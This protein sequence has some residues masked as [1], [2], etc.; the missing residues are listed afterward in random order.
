MVMLMG[1][2]DLSIGSIILVSAV[3]T[4][5]LT[6]NHGLA[7]W[8]AIGAG[9]LAA[10]GIGL[11]NGIFIA[12]IGIEPII[13]TLGTLIAAQGLG[14][15]ILANEG[16]WIQVTNPFF[17]SVATDQV[18]TLPLMA[19]IMLGFYAAAAVLLRD[20]ALGRHIYAIGGNRRAARLAGIPMGR[21]VL[22]TYA[23]CGL[24]AGMAGMLEIAQLGI[25]SQ[26][27]GEGMQFNAITAVLVGGISLSGGSGR[28]EKTLLGILIVGT[29]T[30]YLT[31]RGVSAYYEQAITGGI[32]LAAVFLDHATR[33]RAQ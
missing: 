23:L 13:V 32:I 30:N 25:V 22:A 11:V 5:A 1:G 28:V 31:F 7:A 29:I 12:G 26:N 19:V 14:Q 20:T 15:A 16:S 33:R 9:L 24:C 21:V 4:G 17:F 10:T 3:I 6:T 8:P 27:V 18:L 2:I